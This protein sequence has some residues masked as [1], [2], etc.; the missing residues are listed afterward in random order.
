MIDVED[1]VV[2][3]TDGW[4]LAFER[5]N[6]RKKPSFLIFQFNSIRGQVDFFK[7]KIV[8]IFCSYL[9][10]MG[11]SRSPFFVGLISDPVERSDET[12]AQAFPKTR[13]AS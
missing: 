3:M 2:E 10:F 1:G 5:F 12:N 11:I 7:H 8:S 9:K 4:F 13:V 6:Y